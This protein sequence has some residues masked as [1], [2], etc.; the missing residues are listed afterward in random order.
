[1]FLVVLALL[2]LVLFFLFFKLVKAGYFETADISVVEKPEILGKNV[3]IFY[4][5]YVGS[6]SNVGR[7]IN[8]VRSLLPKEAKI[9]AIYYDDSNKVEEDLCQAA[10]GC[11]Y[12]VDGEIEIEPN[13]VTQLSR[14]GYERMIINKVGRSVQLTQKYGVLFSN[15]RLVRRSYPQLAQYIRD[16]KFETPLNVE[17]YHDDKV[18]ILSPLDET[19]EL[20]VPEY[21]PTDELIQRQLQAHAESFNDDS[22]DSEDDTEEVESDDS[23]GEG[24]ANN[25]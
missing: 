17:L 22:S 2:A 13:F 12:S 5:Y 10:V 23:D 9:I 4:K 1:M 18:V 20:V 3:E 11:V 21:L 25:V 15:L 7:Y 8:E 24:D 6:Y 14:W 19:K 16:Q